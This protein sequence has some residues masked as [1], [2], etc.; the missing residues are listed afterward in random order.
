M[1]RSLRAAEGWAGSR[2]VVCRRGDEGSEY[3]SGEPERNAPER[4][5]A[6][7]MRFGAAGTAGPSLQ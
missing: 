3:R 5:T 2:N 1:C 6:E 4:E 7:E